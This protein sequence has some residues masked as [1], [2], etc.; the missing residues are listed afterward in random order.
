MNPNI[1]ADV[2][3]YSRGSADGVFPP[4]CRAAKVTEVTGDT[5]SLVVFNP[6]GLYFDT[7]VGYAS[8][9]EPGS[10]HYDDITVEETT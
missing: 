9:P 7:G 4:L 8:P 10:W 1:G 2:H 5:V 3:Y 6:K